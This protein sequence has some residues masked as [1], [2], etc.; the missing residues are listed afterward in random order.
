MHADLAD[1]RIVRVSGLTLPEMYALRSLRM[2]IYKSSSYALL[3][4]SPALPRK[5]GTLYVSIFGMDFETSL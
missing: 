1:F 5:R 3:Y 4:V 2:C